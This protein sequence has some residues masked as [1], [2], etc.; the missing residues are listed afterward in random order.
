[1]RRASP[2]RR[3]MWDP[4]HLGLPAWCKFQRQRRRPCSSID[5]PEEECTLVMRRKVI[6]GTV[7]L[8][9]VILGTPKGAVQVYYP[10]LQNTKNTS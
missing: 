2:L 1:M 9:T 10:P 4:Q 8:G 7:I 5:D 6:L 3:N